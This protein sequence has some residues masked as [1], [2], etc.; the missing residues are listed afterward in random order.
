MKFLLISL[1][2]IMCSACRTVPQ[3]ATSSSTT[4]GGSVDVQIY[5]SDKLQLNLANKM[6]PQRIAT[7]FES[8]GVAYLCTLDV[9]ENICVYSFD[10]KKKTLPEILTFLGHEVGVESASKTKGCP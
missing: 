8:L 2:I 4:P 6:K 10:T 1:L 5:Q 9:E 7:S 3:P